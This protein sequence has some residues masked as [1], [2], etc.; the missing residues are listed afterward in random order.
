MIKIS[1]NGHLTLG[2]SLVV[3]VFL[4]LFLR[5]KFSDATSLLWI[6]LILCRRLHLFVFKIF[7]IT[8]LLFHTKKI[9]YD[10]PRIHRRVHRKQFAEFFLLVW[11]PFDT[12]T[13]QLRAFIF[14]RRVSIRKKRSSGHPPFW[15]PFYISCILRVIRKFW[16]AL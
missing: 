12:V 8:V 16:F 2:K 3:R 11:L 5:E 15:I 4:L 7:F 10:G 14:I 6:P 13:N 9:A 1:A